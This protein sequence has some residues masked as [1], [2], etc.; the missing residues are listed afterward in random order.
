MHE[1]AI[2]TAIVFT[3]VF[4][5]NEAAVL[6]ADVFSVPKLWNLCKI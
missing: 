5:A 4:A 1:L 3:P 2:L 6:T